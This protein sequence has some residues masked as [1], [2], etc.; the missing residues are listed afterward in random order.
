M[1]FV[2]SMTNRL[3][4]ALCVGLVL[5][6]GGV[7][8]ERTLLDEGATRIT[9]DEAVTR[10]IARSRSWQLAKLR[11]SLRACRDWQALTRS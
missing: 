6:G 2:G 7:A 3:V 4:F 11:T 8:Q 5:A 10:A 9:L 1:T